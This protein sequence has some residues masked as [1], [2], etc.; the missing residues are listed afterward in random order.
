MKH[1][2]RKMY[3]LCQGANE[4]PAKVFVVF[5]LSTYEDDNKDQNQ[6]NLT[7]QLTCSWLQRLKKQTYKILMC[8]FLIAVSSSNVQH[9]SRS[10]HLL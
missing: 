4:S 3:I 7:F 10:T 8:L 1:G 9:C 2:T 5:V 6:E